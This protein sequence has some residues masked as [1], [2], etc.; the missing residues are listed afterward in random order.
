MAAYYSYAA[1]PL[2]AEGRQASNAQGGLAGVGGCPAIV[3]D[4]RILALL[5]LGVLVG[6]IGVDLHHLQRFVAQVALEGKELAA[7]QQEPDGVPVAT[8][9]GALALVRDAADLFQ[10]IE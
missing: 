7:F 4:G 3:G 10:P 9:V 2:S 5:V 1:A 8:S 6:D